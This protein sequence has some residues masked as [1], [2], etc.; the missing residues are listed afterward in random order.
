M[1]IEAT[2]EI[3]SRIAGAIR[4]A[5]TATGASFDYLLKTALRESNLD[6]NAKAASSSATGLFQFIDQT[7]LETLKRAG[8]QLGYGR[9]AESIV[10]TPSGR[11][12]VSDPAQ[13]RAVMNLRKDPTA[14][15]AMAG[16]LTRQNAAILARKLGRQASDGELYI[17]HFLGP[18]GATKL[19]T[20]AEANPNGKAARLFPQ[21]AKA[22]RSIFYDAA[23]AARGSRQVY[24]ALVARH[25]GMQAS[26][27]AATAATA[28]GKPALG[29]AANP[30][31]SAPA[32]TIAS[33]ASAQ[34]LPASTPAPLAFAAEPRPVFHGLFRTDARAPLSTAVTEFWAPRHASTG[35]ETQAPSIAPAA[36]SGA[37]APPLDLTR[38]V[39]PGVAGKARLGT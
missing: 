3:A 11:Y 20:Q 35:G 24:A 28:G 10:Q 13:R 30:G 39:R 4:D 37:S 6:P 38:F 31:D 17:A 7:W 34:E 27:A 36:P 22:N 25:D 23:G 5:A 9:Y 1:L 19:I 12:T 29:L 32:G 16:A 18:T 8:P 2:S 14:A 15:A 21:A 33:L 26:F